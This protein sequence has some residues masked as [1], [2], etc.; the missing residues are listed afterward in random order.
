MNF[1]SEISIVDGLIL[2]IVSMLIIFLILIIISFIV[3]G[4]RLVFHKKEDTDKPIKEHFNKEES[5]ALNKDQKLAAVIMTAIEAFSEETLSNDEKLA[6]QAAEI[7]TKEIKL[8]DQL[9]IKRIEKRK[10]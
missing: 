3:E 5:F 8:L 7:K 4:F 9:N 1:E 10:R 6:I 2:S